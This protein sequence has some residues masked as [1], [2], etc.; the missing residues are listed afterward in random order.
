M[1]NSESAIE[2]QFSE[3]F[4]SRS[5]GSLFIIFP[6]IYWDASS[7]EGVDIFENYKVWFEETINFI[8]KNTNSNIIIKEHPAILSKIARESKKSCSEIKLFLKK[9]NDRFQHRYIYIEPDTNLST[10]DLIQISD[11]ILTVRGTP[12]VEA[13]L[14]GKKVIFAGTG[15]YDNFEF[16]LIAK[17]I[18]DYYQILKSASKA[19]LKVDEKEKFYSALYLDIVLNKMAFKNEITEISYPNK[20]KS[21][22]AIRF[23]NLKFKEINQNVKKLSYWLQNP[24]DFFDG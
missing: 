19:E 5:N 3:D 23:S 22:P 18:N 16:G 11:Y 12:G 1:K 14:F 7:E 2:S 20:A 8:L 4:L 21:E 13:A 6:H 15:R 9:F 17:D 24:S 10:L